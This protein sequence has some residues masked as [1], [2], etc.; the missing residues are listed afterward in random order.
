MRLLREATQQ[1]TQPASPEGGW[2][3]GHLA[4]HG[5]LL[6]CDGF[7]MKL[8]LDQ[9]N[10]LF[11]YAEDGIGGEIRDHNGKVIFVEVNDD[12][13]ILSR[14]DDET[15]PN[16]VVLDLD[17]LEK[18]GIE[19][20]DD[21]IKNFKDTDDSNK[22][23]EGIKRAYRRVGNKIKRGFRVTSGWRKG[24][25]VSS[26]K[27]AFAPRAKA[28]TRMK[29]KIAARRKKIVRILKGKRTRRKSTSKRLTSMNKRVGG[30]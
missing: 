6:S 25:V 4:H 20:H 12:C 23:K 21:D 16:G 22:L 24:R 13:I 30:K 15:Y 3:V 5:I 28:K 14:D 26:A 2:N 8:D 18:I 29:L 7:S 1:A 10:I 11:D 19:P 9:L 27:G 17:T